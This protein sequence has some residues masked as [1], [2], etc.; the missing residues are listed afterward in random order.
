MRVRAARFTKNFAEFANTEI[1]GAMVLLASTAIALLLANSSAHVAYEAFWHAEV[2]I[3]VGSQHVSLTLF[4]LIDNALMALFFLVVGLEIKREILVGELATRRQATLPFIAAVGGMIVPALIFTMFNLGGPGERGWGIPMATDIAFAIG[5]MALLG[6]RVPQGLKVFL[7][8]LAIVDDLGAILVIAFAYTA[9]L[10]FG[11][12][13]AAAVALIAL[14]LLNRMKVDQL[15]PYLVVGAALWLF[16][17]LSGI[18]STIAGVLIALTI[19]A[20]A[21][22]DCKDFTYLARKR[23]DEIDDVY[24]PG[25]HVLEDDTP[26]RTA[27]LIRRSARHTAAPLQR[28]EFALHPWTTFLILPLFALANAGVRVVGLDLGVVVTAP[29]TLGVIFGLV[30]GKPL[31]IVGATWIAHRLHLVDLPT[32]TRWPQIIGAGML[33]GIGFTMSIFVTGLAFTGALEASE[34]KAAIIAA[35]VIAGCLGYL[36]LRTTGGYKVRE[37]EE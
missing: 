6:D 31:G 36:V 9:D 11:W 23:L 16:I 35:S 28:L 27:R 29:I 32:G 33:A 13:G 34:A 25:A 14:V 7:T 12:L 22:L 30:V 26:Q 10:A 17:L 37:T 15:V 1:L 20:T 2:G 5:V 21:K 18:H 3:L 8:S 24:V 4:E 19:P